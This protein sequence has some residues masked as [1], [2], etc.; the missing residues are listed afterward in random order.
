MIVVR[1]TRH[2]LLRLKGLA[3]DYHVCVFDTPVVRS[4]VMPYVVLSVR[5]A[6]ADQI[7]TFLA[8]FSAY[9]WICIICS[10]LVVFV[11]WIVIGKLS[12]LGTYTVRRMRRI[13]SSDE[14]VKEFA[15]ESG[16]KCAIW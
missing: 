4:S 9:L 12:P 11:V 1:S 14:D 16:I 5:A 3:E 6:F 13:D 8:P 15:I 10:A 2:A 7:F